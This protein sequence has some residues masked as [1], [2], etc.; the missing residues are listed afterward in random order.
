MKISQRKEK[1]NQNQVMDISVDVHK[2]VL[3]FFFEA[4]NKEYSDECQNRTTAIMA[5]LEAYRQIAAAYGM[6]TLRV[7]CEPTG[8]YHNKLLRTARK[9]G[10]LTCFVS[11]ESV[12]RFRVI[13][14]NDTGKTDTKDPRV[15]RT[16]GQLN[17]VI[18]HRTIGETYMMLRKLGTMY[19]EVDQANT[20]LRCRIERL[21]VD[22]F[23][24]Y[25]FKKDFLYTP[26]GLGLIE[27]FGCNPY[28]IVKAGYT[29]FTARMKKAAPRIREQTL[30]RLWE[31]AVSSV[32]NAPPERYVATLESHL[33]LLI[34]D[35]AVQARRKDDLVRNMIEILH[36]LR[37]EDPRIPPATPGVI[38]DKNMARLLGETGPLSDFPHWRTLMR[39]AGLNIRMRQ[40]GKYQGQNKISKK[41]RPLMRRVL[42]HI[43]L[44]LVREGYLYGTY[45][46]QKKNE[47][48]MPGN[49]AMTCVA[50]HFLKKFYG[51]YKSGEAFNLQRFFSCETQSRKVA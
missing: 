10:F 7:L 23:C 34:T 14:T 15:I 2:G 6:E 27:A 21:L 28:R 25:S 20:R 43:V 41:G 4:G 11:A 3:N 44:P 36:L 30:Q 13:E 37:E 39:Y 18:M 16:L 8:Q 45:Y 50:R 49:K 24:D 51:W 46:A 32:R 17:K 42:Q 5:K 47:E 12:A 33:R 38:N 29:R 19:D 22:L 26:S 40:S 1:C 35:W 9:M 31:D 48:K